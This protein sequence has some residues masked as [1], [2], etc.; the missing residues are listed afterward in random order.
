MYKSVASNPSLPAN[1]ESRDQLLPFKEE[2]TDNELPYFG[3]GLG[4]EGRLRFR[5][6]SKSI[7]CDF[8]CPPASLR[9]GRED[10]WRLLW[11]EERDLLLFVSWRDLGST[12]D[13]ESCNP[14]RVNAAGDKAIFL[15]P[16]SP[17]TCA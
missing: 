5:N 15:L 9:W 7:D 12:G 1:L 13:G 11:R 2:A 4:E 6:L 14:L 10:D 3:V 8:F 16:N 17:E